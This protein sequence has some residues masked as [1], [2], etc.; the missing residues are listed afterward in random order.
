LC[1]RVAALRDNC[2]GGEK[3]MEGGSP[4]HPHM[5]QDVPLP[6][7]RFFPHVGV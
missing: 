4:V 3:A 1:E 2:A 5:R 7:S 6:L